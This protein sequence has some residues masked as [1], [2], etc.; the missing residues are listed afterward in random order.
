MAEIAVEAGNLRRSRGVD[1]RF[2]CV[3]GGAGRA[4]VSTHRPSRFGGQVAAR[5]RDRQ[6]HEEVERQLG[7]GVKLA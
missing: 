3:L 2:G 7:V 5:S 6:Y 1:R 4:I